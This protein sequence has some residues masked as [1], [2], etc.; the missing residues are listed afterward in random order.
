MP[1][2]AVSDAV[3]LGVLNLI[4]IMFMAWIKIKQD[5]AEKKAEER[6]DKLDI[7]S[8]QVHTIEKATNSMKDAL[9]KATQDVGIANTEAAKQQGEVNTKAAFAEG[10]KSETDKGKDNG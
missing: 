9:V 1:I 10:V 4:G 8:E 6:S 5:K 7:V 3:W 2:L